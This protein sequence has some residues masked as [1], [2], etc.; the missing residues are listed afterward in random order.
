[1]AGTSY[2]D[3]LE[4]YANS[5][6][7]NGFFFQQDGAPSHYASFVNAVFKQVDRKNRIH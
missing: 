2:L 1:M 6:I 4:N 3:M 7:L 5:Q